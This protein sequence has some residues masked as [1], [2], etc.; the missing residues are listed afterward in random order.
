MDLSGDA[1]TSQLRRL[2]VLSTQ[3]STLRRPGAC[4]ARRFSVVAAKEPD[5]NSRAGAGLRSF[6]PPMIDLSLLS[7]DEPVDRNRLAEEIDD[8]FSTVGFCLITN[9]EPGLQR[10]LDTLRSEAEAYFG[11]SDDAKLRSRVDDVFGYLPNGVESVAASIGKD[12][13]PDLVEGLCFNGRDVDAD[14][15]PK[16]PEPTCA[17]TFEGQGWSAERVAANCA[18]LDKDWVQA[19]PKTL[20]DA[21]FEYWC[22]LS[23]LL[24]TMMEL[25]SLAFDLPPTFFAEHGYSHPGCVLRLANYVDPPASGPLKGQARYNAHT[26]YDGFTFLSRSPGQKGLEI[27]L[28]NGEWV[29]VSPPPDCLI[30]NIGDLLARWSNDRWKATMHRVCNPTS[31]AMEE[32][33]RLSVVF[34]SGPHP[35]TLVECLPSDKCRSQSPSPK[36][37]PVTAEAHVRE[38]LELAAG[39]G[40]A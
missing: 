38:K 32:D 18:W 8:V 11:L 10:S 13:P 30:V 37:P 25:A 29:S 9:Y 21:A 15:A 24:D 28:P 2:R 34:F 4:R 39:V 23:R 33:S 20:R 6:M 19:V 35:S 3:L 5:S 7:S 31:V 36:Y 12:A 17:H 26:D 1:T 27:Q 14:G 22:G 40:S 16:Q